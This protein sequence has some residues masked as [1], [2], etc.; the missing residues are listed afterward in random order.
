MPMNLLDLTAQVR[1]IGRASIFYVA[2]WDGTTD[3]PDTLTHLG[4][5]EG[6]V[7][8]EPNTE[9]S[10]LVLPE[11]TGP[12]IHERYLSGDNP[13]ISL[14]LYL[15]DPSLRAIVTPKGSGSGGYQRQR[16][17]DE[18]TLVL[19]PEQLFIESDAQAA[20][21]FTTAGGWTV[22]G[23]AAS[24]AQLALIDQAMWFW[25]GHFSRPPMTFRHEDHGKAVDEVMFQVMHADLATSVIPDGQRL[26]TYGD[27]ED[28]SI[29]INPG[30]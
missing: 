27:P 8:L 5:T 19:F 28:A 13:E 21:D 30:G 6:E 25:R 16:S 3:L 12:A 10:D 15:A 23:D 9:Y 7:T 26:W 20:V 4:D 22:G 29:D 14:P 2:K 11:L 1:D 24:A 17:V 18:Y